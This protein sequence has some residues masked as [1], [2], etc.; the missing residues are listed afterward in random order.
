[1]L[2]KTSKRKDD[3]LQKRYSFTHFFRIITKDTSRIKKSD[4]KNDEKST[5]YCM[6]VLLTTFI[7]NLIMEGFFSSY[8]VIY[9]S[10]VNEFH[11]SRAVAGWVGSLFL[12]I[13]FILGPF[14]SFICLK[15]GCRISAFCGGLITGLGWIC[16]SFSPE[17]I[18]LSVSL[19]LI[20]ALG[21]S[22]VAIPTL[23]IVPFYFD[24]RMSLAASES[25]IRYNYLPISIQAFRHIF[26]NYY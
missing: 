16:A 23:V 14:T 26:F 18:S 19:G 21:L 25:F 12:S 1:M 2:S 9:N 15:Y 3:I 4:T 24:E 10:V 11:V 5:W 8:N 22:L 6:V 13:P 20:T 7:S 17:I